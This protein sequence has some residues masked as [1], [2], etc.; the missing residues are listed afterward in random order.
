M[1]AQRGKAL[2]LIACCLG[3]GAQFLLCLSAAAQ[4]GPA[5]PDVEVAALLADYGIEASEEPV[6]SRPGWRPPEHVLMLIP[7]YVTAARPDY[8]AWIQAAAGAAKLTISSDPD[9]LR[10]LAPDAD[11]VLGSCR[12]LADPSPQLRWFQRDG[13]GMEDCLGHPALQNEAVLLTNSATLDGPYVAEHALTMMLMLFHRM[14]Q[15]YANQQRGVWDRR[16]AFQQ[17]IRPVRGQTL[18]IV[19]LGGIGTQIAQRAASLGMHVIATRNSRAEGP[20]YVDYVGLSTELLELAARADVVISTVPLTPATENLYDRDFFRTMKPSAYF[21]NVARG[22]SVVT[23]DLVAALETG[24]I[25]GA[26]LDV[27]EPDPLPP[28]HPLWTLPN[29]LITPHTATR[30]GV[31]SMDKIVFARENLRRYTAGEPML[32]VVDRERGY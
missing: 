17:A 19:G 12:I 16:P 5:E 30:S 4:P 14:H 10:A 24:E 22:Q 13:A 9:E 28:S 2:G 15:Y 29:V 25:A 31:G 23:Q 8:A 7:E 26:A 27:T 20:D 32:N 1:E 18:L 11:V 21:I 3:M 6:R